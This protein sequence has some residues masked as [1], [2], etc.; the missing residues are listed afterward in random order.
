[1]N[2][3]EIAMNKHNLW[4]LAQQHQVFDASLT[5]AEMIR[6]IQLAEGNFDCY[7]RA[8]DGDCDQ[9]ECLWRRDCLL[10]SAAAGKP[11]TH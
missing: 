8:G 7:A 6:K 1:L 10:E 11:Q 2:D 9:S 4:K 3:Q 5:K